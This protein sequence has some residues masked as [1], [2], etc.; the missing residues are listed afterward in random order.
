[1]VK[2]DKKDDSKKLTSDFTDAFIEKII[3]NKV[4]TEKQYTL[5]FEGIF[6][7]RWFED[8]RIAAIINL[9]ILYNKKYCNVPKLNILNEIIKKYCEKSSKEISEYTEI[10]LECLNLKIDVDDAAIKAN[11]EFY[12]KNKGVYYTI[13]DGIEDLEKTKDVSK[14]IEKF[15]KI[16][17]ITFDND[18]GFD[19]FN[20]LDEHINYLINPDAKLPMGIHWL[21]EVTCGG[22]L[23]DG[24]CLAVFM[25]QPGLG[26]SLML[27]N[28]AYRWLKQDKT[29]VI[30]SCEMSKDV[31]GR[32]IDALISNDNIDEL[33][34]TYKESFSKIR[35]FKAEHPDAK[36]FI[37]EYP[38]TSI[39]TNDIKLYIDSLISKG[40]KPDAIVIDYLNLVLPNYSI[41]GGGSYF[42]ILQVSQNF[43]A[44][45]YLYNCPVITATQTN[46]EGINNANVGLEHISESKGT[47]H[48][49]DFIC[50]LYQLA[51]DIDAGIINGKILKNRLGGKHGKVHAFR[52]NEKTLMLEDEV[53]GDVI[54]L[55][56]SETPAVTNNNE[57]PDDVLND[58]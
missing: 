39:K 43:R 17:N 35:H 57:I 13:L 47:G 42:N 11:I 54:Q 33:H 20:Q 41:E 7:K 22:L 24:R 25:A 37:K 30:I 46:G 19:Y 6:D 9:I 32:R 12:V 29:V 51:D 56:K 2:K 58:I 3:L 27:A 28:L 23:K 26:K 48:T 55:Q 14:C 49:G 4:Y 16:N 8:D 44:L 40:I 31:Y 15:E 34:L 36:L 18:V 52:L 38:P 53:C 5:F 45:S 10:L 21:D 1:M 50:A